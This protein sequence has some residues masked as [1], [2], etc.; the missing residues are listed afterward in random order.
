[1]FQST[2]RYDFTFGIPGE[3]LKDGPTRSRPGF[4]QSSNA[5][6]NIIGATA[7]TQAPAGGA[8]QA[9]GAAGSI[10]AGILAN[11]KVYPGYGTVAGGP[12]APT[13]T[14]PN[15]VQGEFLEMGYMVVVLANAGVTI[16]DLLMFANATG[17]LSSLKPTTSFTAAQALG[18]LTVTAAAAGASLGV[19]SVVTQ[20][21]V[22]LGTIVS[23]GTGTGGN[24][25]YNLNTSA[26]VTA[27]V[28]TA[29]NVAPAGSTLIARAVVD[30]LPQPA[31]NGLALVKLTQ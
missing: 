31:A 30:E 11:P 8:V 22:I 12:L 7:F 14:L 20:A 26:T 3:I 24:G 18:V 15:N 1:M 10:F 4:I 13:L 19:G 21:G 6:L 27:G 29:T 17:V 28:A 9:G 16:G 23:L 25:T 2:L 5:A